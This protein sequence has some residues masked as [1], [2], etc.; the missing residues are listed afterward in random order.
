MSSTNV[1]DDQLPR[2]AG[3]AAEVVPVPAAS[4]LL[5]RDDPLRVLM[6]RR[7]E[8]ST[9]V[10]GVW[11]FPGGALEAD[12]RDIGD[13]TEI[14]AMRVAAARELFEETGIWL[15]GPP[16]D[17]ESKRRALLAGQTAFAA[18]ARQSPPQLERLVWTSR[19]IT[20][21]GVPKRF[22]TWFFLATADPDAEATAD[23]DEAVDVIWIRPAEAIDKLPIVFPTLKNVEAIA[24]F[25]SV[26]ELLASRRNAD[27][28]TIRP[29][30]VIEGSVKR[31]VL[32]D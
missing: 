7:H 32:P 10:P 19:W 31:I 6:I 9:F 24:G 15:G 14:G 26:D 11:V 13:G 20:P 28:P 25:T 3:D 8:K 2:G 18:L 23:L 29:V 27:I 22:D 21:S 30:L 1:R 16:Q 4:V 12:D 17:A 5:L